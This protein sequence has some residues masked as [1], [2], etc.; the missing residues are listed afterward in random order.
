MIKCAS[1]HFDDQS[2]V[3][4]LAQGATEIIEGHAKNII[5]DKLQRHDA[6]QSSINFRSGQTTISSSTFAIHDSWPIVSLNAFLDVSFMNAN[7]KTVAFLR[8][9]K[10]YTL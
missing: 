3:K 4:V 6:R 1:L 2:N 8:I 9:S 10:L 7:D 5:R